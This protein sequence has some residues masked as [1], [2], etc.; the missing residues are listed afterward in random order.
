MINQIYDLNIKI[1]KITTNI[2]CY[3]NLSSKFPKLII[4]ALDQQI[5]ELKKYSDHNIT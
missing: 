4:K 3:R 1:N 5:L 2:N